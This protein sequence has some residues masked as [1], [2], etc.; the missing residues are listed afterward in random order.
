M[1]SNQDQEAARRLSVLAANPSAAAGLQ[2][3]LP[4]PVGSPAGSGLEQQLVQRIGQ[5]S[6]PPTEPMQ[7]PIIVLPAGY[8]YTAAPEGGSTTQA[9]GLA[10][11]SQPVVARRSYLYQNTVPFAGTEVTFTANKKFGPAEKSA[12]VQ[13]LSKDKAGSLDSK[14]GN[15]NNNNHNGSGG[16]SP[17]Y[18]QQKKKSVSSIPTPTKTPLPVIGGKKTIYLQANK[19]ERYLYSL[20]L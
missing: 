6:A 11:Q 1:K 9:S 13:L 3:F 14:G 10:S 19:T 5:P 4:S 18:K 7:Q 20:L 2:L 17:G 8:S 12:Q 16:L 15:N